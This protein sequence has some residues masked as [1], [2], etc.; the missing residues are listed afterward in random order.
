MLEDRGLVS[1]TFIGNAAVRR[2]A[3]RELLDLAQVEAAKD[4]NIFRTAEGEPD[5]T[6]ELTFGCSINSPLLTD[7]AGR[8]EHVQW[9]VKDMDRLTMPD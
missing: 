5:N 7:G 3:M 1:T 4:Y 9:C 2:F 6:T 8:S